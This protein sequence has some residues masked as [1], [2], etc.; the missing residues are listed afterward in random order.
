M[1]RTIDKNVDKKPNPLVS[2][3]PGIFLCILVMFLGIIGAELIGVALK[4]M[5][6]LVEDSKTPISGI[7]VAILVGIIIRNLMELPEM[8]SKGISFSMKYVL[9]AGIILLGFRLSLMEALKLGAFGIPLIIAC[10]GIGLFVTLYLTNKLNQSMRL[11][12]L[13]AS[14]TGICGVTAIMATSPVIKAKENEISYAVANITIFGLTGML[15]YPFLANW[16]FADDPIKAGLFL[17]TAIHD[18]AQVTGAALIYDQIFQTQAVVEAATVTK[19]TRNLFIIA[20]IPLVSYLFVKRAV[21][22][23]D[24]SDEKAVIPKWYSF[25]P[26]FV[27]G[28]LIVSVIRSIGDFTLGTS[29][30]AFG[31]IGET[32]WQSVY[33]QLSS[34]GT[35]YLLGI[36]MAGV[37]LSTNFKMFK[38]LGLKPF[39]IGLT[40]ALSVGI[41]SIILISLFGDLV[42]FI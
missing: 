26:L 20:I 32:H 35:T 27:I 7:F 37:G 19:L 25:I 9:R 8:F 28:F 3:L 11:G 21:N 36:A 2:I 12:T 15:L 10:I 23:S 17:G 40:A 33:T 24:S 18:T 16:I 5:G 6:F 38:G 42:N 31:F 41:V 4:S 30:S 14:G 34:F 22:E 1:E 39:Y 29:G 13:I